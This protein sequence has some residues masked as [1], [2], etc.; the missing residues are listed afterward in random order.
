MEMCYDGTLVMPSSYA[1]M[2]EEEMTY[3][4]GGKAITIATSREYLSKSKCKEKARWLLKYNYCNN[5]D[6]MDIAKEIHA[7]AFYGYKGGY[8]ALNMP[9]GAL[10]LAIIHLAEKGLNGISL[11]DHK[12]SAARVAAYNLAWL[13]GKA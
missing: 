5:M 7:H 6:L 10:K 1:V 11:E 13:L 3:V 4:E 8:L 9:D 2:D 12:D